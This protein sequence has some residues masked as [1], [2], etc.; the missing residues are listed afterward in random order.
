MAQQVGYDQIQPGWEVYA[1]D[2]EHLGSVS[3]V[4]DTYITMTKGLFLPKDYFIPVNGIER[5]DTEQQQISLA[6]AKGD[7]DRM[8]WDNPG[9]AES[10]RD[11]RGAEQVYS[12]GV[13]ET[14]DAETAGTQR[15][16]RYEEELRADKTSRQAGEV[17]LNKDVT[18]EEQ[19]FD[20]PVTRED[21][22]VRRV[23][24]NRPVGQN[25][26]AFQDGDTIRVPV[27]EEQVQVTK[28]PRVVEELEIRK[29]AH[30]ETQRV[31]DTVR[32]EQINVERQGD[33]NVRGDRELAG[34]GA[35]TDRFQGQG[36]LDRQDPAMR[37]R[38][39]E[40]QDDEL[41]D[42]VEDDGGN[43]GPAPLL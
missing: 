41:E 29:G 18:E 11:Y 3:D 40:F 32:K 24:V 43:S 36:D 13:N 33:V 12:G 5:V 35:G 14:Q 2:G 20:V 9:V 1:N 39:A 34:A 15:V 28:E 27:R 6:C 22:E 10:G 23:A 26:D 42:D 30:Q 31:S 38:G 19:A 16:Q 7:L 25:E 37:N 4:N 8:G 21:V 17:R